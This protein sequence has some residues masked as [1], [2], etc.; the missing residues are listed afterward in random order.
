MDHA[1]V[2]VREVVRVVIREVVR[3]VA[4]TTILFLALLYHEVDGA[5]Y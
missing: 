3:E 5:T 2:V 4:R 1:R